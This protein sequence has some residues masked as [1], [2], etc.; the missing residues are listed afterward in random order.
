MIPLV[1][2]WKG[3]GERFRRRA[4]TLTAT[5]ND[6]LTLIAIMFNVELN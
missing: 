4:G 5:M 3:R 1:G 2:N 6:V